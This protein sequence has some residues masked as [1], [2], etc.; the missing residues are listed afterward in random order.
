MLL[1]DYLSEWEQEEEEAAA[2]DRNVKWKTTAILSSKSC[3]DM[4]QV[5]FFLSVIDTFIL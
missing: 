2:G 5:L 1:Y 4:I 3:P